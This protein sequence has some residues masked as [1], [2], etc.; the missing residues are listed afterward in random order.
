MHQVSLLK[1]KVAHEDFLFIKS[2]AAS[3]GDYRGGSFNI[4]VT[5]TLVTSHGFPV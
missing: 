3:S 5:L 2:S 1:E 4:A